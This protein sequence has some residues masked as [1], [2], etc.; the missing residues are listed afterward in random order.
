M[1]LAMKELI[2][3]EIVPE[4]GADRGTTENGAKGPAW[5]CGGWGEGRVTV[6]VAS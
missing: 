4:R 6:A 1:I 5:V 2:E 3:V